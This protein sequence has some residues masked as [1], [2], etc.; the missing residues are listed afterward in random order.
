MAKW[1]DHSPL[2]QRVV[3]LKP[4]TDAVILS[5]KRGFTSSLSF[6]AKRQLRSHK[7]QSHRDEGCH[8]TPLVY[9]FNGLH[10]TL[11]NTLQR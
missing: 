11:T 3:G 9:L 2:I 1:L 8:T 4:P 10:F 7:V 6:Q 5:E